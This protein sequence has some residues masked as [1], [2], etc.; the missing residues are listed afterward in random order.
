MYL[1]LAYINRFSVLT[2]LY[3][4]N[5]RLDCEPEILLE[6]ISDPNWGTAKYSGPN[7]EKYDTT[8]NEFNRN[9]FAM[10]RVSASFAV[11]AFTGIW[12]NHKIVY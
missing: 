2:D 12:K 5:L 11:A 4:S 3:C 10:N 1:P 7:K 6:M 8:Y 9:F